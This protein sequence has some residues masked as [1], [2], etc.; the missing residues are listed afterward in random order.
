MR[1][2]EPCRMKF[3]GVSLVMRLVFP[4]NTVYLICILMCCCW[5]QHVE[6]NIV[7]MGVIIGQIFII[8]SNIFRRYTIY[9]PIQLLCLPKFIIKLF[10][11]LVSSTVDMYEMMLSRPHQSRAGEA[12]DKNKIK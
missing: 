12:G 4:L 6:K 10:L 11:V 9:F 3:S 7:I 5:Q 1:D 8:I 2:P